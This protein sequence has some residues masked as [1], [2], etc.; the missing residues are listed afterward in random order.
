MKTFGTELKASRK[1]SVLLTREP[2]AK[3]PKL[4]DS[5]AEM[6]GCEAQSRNC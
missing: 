2:A 5:E 1:K 4:E 3:P 6:M